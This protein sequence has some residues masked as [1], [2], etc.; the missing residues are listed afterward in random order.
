M[1]L[2]AA[3]RTEGIEHEPPPEVLQT[4]LSDFY[5]QYSLRVRLRDQTRRPAVLSALHARI[6]DIFN[7]YGVQIMSPHYRFDPKSPVVVPKERWFAPPACAEGEQSGDG[8]V[9]SR[10]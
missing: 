4:Q 1:L 6:Q 9:R 8:G 10:G 2:D 5:V 7:Q 3:D